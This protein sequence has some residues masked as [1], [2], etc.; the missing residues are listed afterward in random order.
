MDFK[1]TGREGVDWI[2]L[3][4]SRVYVNTEI[5]QPS[6]SIKNGEFLNQLG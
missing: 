3:D 5:N 6:A 1:E 4:Q 2:K